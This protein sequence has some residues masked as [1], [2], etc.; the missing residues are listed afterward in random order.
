MS[1]PSES[2]RTAFLLILA[3]HGSEESQASRRTRLQMSRDFGVS[4]EMDTALVEL[5]YLDVFSVDY[6]LALGQPQM[7][8]RQSV[9]DAYN[10]CL[11]LLDRATINPDA[12][13][14]ER[15]RRFTLYGQAAGHLE[16]TV[17]MM[18]VGGVIAK[19][20]GADDRDVRLTVPVGMHFAIHAGHMAKL[21]TDILPLNS[22][23][24]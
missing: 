4:F 18:D 5:S 22:A 16:D 15:L 10:F 13:F 6:A 9:R 1:L 21:L 2:I 24:I 23:G 20:C 19:L 12:A 11:Q 14:E 8:R 17:R 7:A 3:A